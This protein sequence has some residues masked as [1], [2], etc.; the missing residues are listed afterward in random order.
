MTQP[1]IIGANIAALALLVFGMYVPRYHRK[2]MVVA[3]IGLNMGVMA[4]ATALASAEVTAGLG[5]GLFGV[6]S[7]IRLRSS[8]L[9]QEEVAYYFSALALGLL[10][11]FE[12][13]PAWLTPSLMAAIVAAL[14]I[15]DHP[16]LLANHRHQTV[17]L[18]SAYT[19]ESDLRARLEQLLD[20]EIMQI[21][22]KRVDLVNDTTSVDVRFRLRPTSVDAVPQER[23]LVEA[24]VRS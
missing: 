18:D 2:D 17:Q 8:E 24:G 19:R 23:T 7:I 9:A 11:G 14:F 22:V 13:S 15:G 5:L 3:I 20:A 10:A 6:L 4:V 21:K 1:L 12:V 16:R